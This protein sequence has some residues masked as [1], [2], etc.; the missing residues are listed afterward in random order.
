[1]MASQDAP[2]VTVSL[3]SKRGI[4]WDD[5]IAAA[6]TREAIAEAER[7]RMELYD[8]IETMRDRAAYLRGRVNLKKGLQLP[9][10]DDKR[11]LGALDIIIAVAQSALASMGDE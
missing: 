4:R 10:K 3:L 5:L 6:E 9:V 11:E 2:S 1:M 7:R 8:A